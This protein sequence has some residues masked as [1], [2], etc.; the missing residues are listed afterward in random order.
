M[1]P[2]E[3]PDR[4]ASDEPGTSV[5]QRYLRLLADVAERLLAA[6]DP[7]DMVDEIFDLMRRELRLDVF[8]NYRVAGDRLVLEAHGGLTGDQ[9]AKIGT[10]AMGEAI[11]G[12][13]AQ[14][15]QIHHAIS[16]R[17]S[18]DPTYAFVRSLGLDSYVCTP[19][20]HGDA[21]LGTLSFGRRWTNRFSADELRFL[22]V[23]CHYVAL[24]K[25][26][27]RVEAAL[28][29][30]M[31]AR[32]RLLGEL[33]HRVRNA[34]Q[35]AVG[36]VGAE[37]GDL[38]SA[39]QAP[40]YRAVDR[41]Q[42][43]AIAHRPLYGDQAAGLVD[44]TGLIEALVEDRAIPAV[45]A[46]TAALAPL[47]VETAAALALLVHTLTLGVPPHRP[48]AIHLAGS[49][50]VVRLRLVGIAANT[51]ASRIARGLLHQLRGT[52]TPATDG[53]ILTLP[54]AHD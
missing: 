12:T 35:V 51:E 43:L 18:D 33:K 30:G 17:T 37:A 49:R 24:A 14:T 1:S 48:V 16:I 3:L 15:R 4:S 21:L 2:N 53:M 52:I 45:L 50:D 25:Y 23:A 29:D 40:L 7:A 8:T 11:C 22:R 31:E 6:A 42:V 26:R 32:E 54:M 20:M 27:L 5:P 19:L 41:L 28:R 34:L 47:R 10:L 9:P 13:V 46:E 38:A 36:L 44:V 39:A